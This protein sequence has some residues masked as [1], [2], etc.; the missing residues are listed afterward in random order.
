VSADIDARDRI[1]VWKV[2]G[3]GSSP[4]FA[5]AG[6]IGV[7]PFAPPPLVPQPGSSNTLDSLDGRLTQAVGR[8][9]PNSGGAEAVWTQHTIATADGR[10][11]VRWYELLPASLGLRQQGDVN[12][13]GLFAF[14]GSISPTSGGN[15]AAIQFNTG[16]SSQLV[17][18]RAQSRR[19]STPLGTM[20][21][22]TT[23]G[24]S[25]AVDHDFTC[26]VPNGPPCR[27]GD[28]SGAS[29]DP[30]DP[31]LVWGS[32]QL[33]G[34]GSGTTP[35]WLTRNFAVVA[36]GRAP[37]PSIGAPDPA[38]KGGP[39]RLDASGSIADGPVVDYAWDLDGNGTF[40]TDTGASPVLTHT[41]T[42][43]G[44]ATVSLRITD[45]RGQTGV[46]TRQINVA[47]HPP[48][49]AF[50]I[51]KNPATIRNA[52]T[53]DASRSTD[54]DGRIVDYMW[55]LDGNGTFETDTGSKPR[56]SHTYAKPMKMTVRLRVRDDDGL[57][58]DA[59]A[60][61]V[62][63]AGL[64]LSLKNRQTLSGPVRLK[65]TCTATC[66]ATFVLQLPRSQARKLHLSRN[67]GSAKRK[68]RTN[69]RMSI[70][71]PLSK[72]A[73]RR[74]GSLSKLKVSLVVT[75]RDASKVPFSVSRGLTLQR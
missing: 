71:V 19:G 58:S 65:A 68:L 54:T 49:A 38:G 72:K 29:P 60:V 2:T 41:F 16:S 66:T 31:T 6:E 23:L 67:I 64:K 11:A 17:D 36:T 45:D 43:A 48:V 50:T 15:D 37:A 57:T 30:G 34:S 73:R 69:K 75:V 47:D 14:N 56:V 52:V 40:E 74:L 42:R 20:A 10:S 5:S 51:T 59:S 28:Y 32:N 63:H 24:Q 46:T 18:I 44:P 53:F 33:N 25:S 1:Q 39:V 12:D 8:A 4:S 3:S 62:S 9:D 13:A 70:S 61:L 27:W 35:R 7:S 21:G 22:E 26:T 55:D